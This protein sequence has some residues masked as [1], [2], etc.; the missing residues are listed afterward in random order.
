MTQTKSWQIDKLIMVHIVYLLIIGSWFVP[1]T[2][3]LWETLDH[4]VFYIMNGWLDSDHDTQVLWAYANKR[5]FDIVPTFF[6][7]SLFFLYVTA[8]KRQFITKRAAQ[9]I[10]IGLFSILFLTLSKKAI[11]IDRHSPSLTM[12]PVHRITLLVPE[13]KTKDS[14]RGSFPGE[15]TMTLSVWVILFWY[16]AGW[17][18]GIF[19]VILAV[20]FSVPRLVA[21]AHW[22][23]DDII[24]GIG[25]AAIGCSWLIF[26]PAKD[27]L[28]EKIEPFADKLLRIVRLHPN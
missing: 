2:A 16:F 8:N 22:M 24:G 15:H 12:D 19:T 23:T 21:G 9:M 11:D 4:S 6:M 17:R 27:Y 13:V 1:I 7:L 20:I 3:E 10:L 25:F 14:S 5:S 28:L 26:S 18:F